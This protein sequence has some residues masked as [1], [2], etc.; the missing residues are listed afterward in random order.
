MNNK[1]LIIRITNNTF[2]L[3]LFVFIVVTAIFL[4]F[5]V[6]KQL[7][8]VLFIYLFIEI[9]ENLI[10]SF[11][12]ELNQGKLIFHY[13]IKKKSEICL[14]FVKKI[15][16]KNEGR[17][18]TVIYVFFDEDKSAYNITNY[19]KKDIEKLYCAIKRKDIAIIYYGK[20]GDPRIPKNINC[21]EIN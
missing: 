9:I 10:L 1:D 20:D 8:L 17:E 3:F 14:N 15:E 7:A 11:K 18:G 4:Y 13:F 16:I 12:I 5:F 6:L 19:S 21:D 2:M